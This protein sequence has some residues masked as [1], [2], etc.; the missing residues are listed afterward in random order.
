MSGGADVADG[1]L[2]TQIVGEDV[3]SQL[4]ALRS[5]LAGVGSE[6]LTLVSNLEKIEKALG[7]AKIL[8]DLAKAQDDLAK[9]QKKVNDQEKETE[10]LRKRQTALEQKQEASEKALTA[11]LN[12]QAKSIKEAREQNKLLTKVRNEINVTTKEGVEQLNR[13]NAK[14]DANNRLIKQN[15]DAALKQKMN[16]G[17]YA[18]ALDDLGGAFGSAGRK[19]TGFLN[20]LKALPGP[21]KAVLAFVGAVGGALKLWATNTARGEEGMFKLNTTLDIFKENLKN[22]LAIK[23]DDLLGGF[24]DLTPRI[25]DASDAITHQ[26]ELLRKE[27]KSFGDWL[28]A[29]FLGVA[30]HEGA[31]GQNIAQSAEEVAEYREEVKE[32]ISKTE[33]F[34]RLVEKFQ[35]KG[36]EYQGRVNQYAQDLFDHQRNTIDSLTEEAELERDIARLRETAANSELTVSEREAAQAQIMAKLGQLESIQVGNAQ[37]NLRLM[38]ERVELTQTLRLAQVRALDEQIAGLTGQKDKEQEL[39]RLQKD[40]EEASRDLLENESR[41]KE[42]EVGLLKLQANFATQ[43]RALAQQSMALSKE[44]Q[45]SRQKELSEWA[46]GYKKELDAQVA[47]AKAKAD[48]L[49]GVY[50]ANESGGLTRVDDLAAWLDARKEYLRLAEEAE[51]KLE[52]DTA[53]KRIE[54]LG[55]TGEEA[56]RVTEQAEANVKAIKV[57]YAAEGE[58]EAAEA[59]RLARK[60]VFDQMR[61]ETADLTASIDEEENMQLYNL[62]QRL[63]AGEL[64]YKQYVK[65]V[66]KIEVDAAKA[67]YEAQLAYVDRLLKAEGVSDSERRNA[68]AQLKKDYDEFRNTVEGAGE[69]ASAEDWAN[70]FDKLKE[71][72]GDAWNVIANAVSTSIQNQLTDLEK[73]KNKEQAD[74][75][76]KLE[77]VKNAGLSQRQQEL[78]T[79]RIEREHAA[80]Q[81]KL[82]EEEAQLKRK[83]AVW[84]KANNLIQATIRTALAVTNA[85]GSMPP[86]ANFAMAAIVGALGAAEIAT[87]AAQKIPEYRTGR[88]GGDAELAIVGDG[89]VSEVIETPAGE[90]VITPAKPTLV[91]LGRGDRVYRD[92]EQ[93]LLS[94]GGDERT[95]GELRA[96]RK[97]RRENDEQLIKAMNNMNAKLAVTSAGLAWLHGGKGVCHARG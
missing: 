52:R 68:L 46:A 41:M 58:K 57:R 16:I 27:K 91:H 26:S 50:D 33:E 63:D 78:E 9:A 72:A 40:R 83:Q 39:A 37:E 38:K 55:L 53:A 77:R 48:E 10:K 86:P 84:D 95:A 76:K 67:R 54:L 30:I 4:D 3:Y 23:M 25:K 36:V 87:I 45:A 1:L 60:A 69:T 34:Q 59:A 43:R 22:S 29:A 7:A 6:V 24:K 94:R 74:Y 44:E 73:L 65:A 49:K 19:V 56:A 51:I 71:M 64:T 32:A 2:I 18:S 75:E 96:L 8:K 85:L 97:E 13:L 90:A 81:E 79:A 12:Q 92:V 80:E 35:L 82:A 17:N 15:G 31:Y 70:F 66:N 11:A 14:I 28:R 93:Y 61:A 47:A 88:M 62:R 42:A 21:L 89:G 20:G 5:K